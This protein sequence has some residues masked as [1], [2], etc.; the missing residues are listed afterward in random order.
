MHLTCSSSGC[1]VFRCYFYFSFQD[2]AFSSDNRLVAVST[3]RGTTHVFPVT[4]YGGPVGVRTHTAPRVVN[5]LSRFHRSAGIDEHRS[6]SATASSSGRN[7]PNPSLPGTSPVFGSF[8][9]SF[10]KL[11]LGSGAGGVGG[12]GDDGGGPPLVV[13][14]PTPYIPPFPTPTLIQ[15]IAQLRQPY[16]V[17]LTNQT[18]GSASSVSRK[19]SINSPTADDPVSVK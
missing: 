11:S 2:I 5:R 7:S 18:I 15:P 4:P 6:T 3:L 19:K 13:P 8:P 1:H 9:S 16:I 10:S 14:Y 12:A 17:T